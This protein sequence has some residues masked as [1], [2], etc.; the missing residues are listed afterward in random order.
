VGDNTDGQAV[1]L[2]RVREA[3]ADI[4]AVES[5]LRAPVFNGFPERDEILARLRVPI[6]EQRDKLASA[7]AA[8][9]T[10]LAWGHLDSALL[11]SVAAFE[12]ALALLGGM[13]LRQA[14]L[15]NNVSLMAHM[16]QRELAER[17]REVAWPKAC[18]P[19][20]E[21]RYHRVSKL[22]RI[23]F[24]NT[25][26]WSLPVV[27]HE[28]GHAVIAG[29]AEVARGTNDNRL[30]FQVEFIPGSQREL[31]CDVI[32]TLGLGPAYVSACLLL[33][34]VPSSASEA[35]DPHPPERERAHVMLW[36]LRELA[37]EETAQRLQAAWVS[38]MQ[39]AGVDEP[40][41][42]E[43]DELAQRIYTFTTARLPELPYTGMDRADKLAQDIEAGRDPDPRGEANM[44]DALN[45][46]WLVRRRGWGTEG[47]L[48]DAT[49]VA[50]HELC[51]TVA[52][53]PGETR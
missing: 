23:R 6:A 43:L 37:Y 18:V 7:R 25:S 45:A 47:A 14:G 9:T 51:R 30:A 40:D 41:P 2:A 49:R 20:V 34:F 10:G 46:A 11:S 38:A 19:D 16:L 36:V 50:C 12:E 15:D 35:F 17:L 21:E 53:R 28:V 5:M 3:E 29:F 52:L 13:L 42:T 44:L 22:I 33:R 8:G 26:I 24:P 39:S 48:D 27:A 31:V 32:A 4:S 1:L